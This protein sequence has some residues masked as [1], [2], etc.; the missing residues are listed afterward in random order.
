[1]NAKAAPGCGRRL[2]V[3]CTE[4][5]RLRAR[6]G[7]QRV[8]RSLIRAG[9]SLP[10]ESILPVAFDGARF[11]E[12]GAAD[13][14]DRLASSGTWSV[15]ERLR[16]A[17]LSGSRSAVLRST[18]LHPALQ[19]AARRGVSAAYWRSRRVRR[20]LAQSRPVAYARSDWIVLLDSTWGPD[21]RP[22]LARARA[23]GA[24]VCVVVYDLIQ[25]R[26][27]DLVS[28]GAARIFSQ[29]IERTLPLA[30]R[31]LTISASV[32]ED[33]RALLAERGMGELATRV[34][35]FHLGCD[36]ADSTEGSPSA[37]VAS[38]FEGGSLPATFLAVGTLEPR[39]AQSTLLDAFET[40]WGRG[41]RSR[42]IL[43]GREGWGSHALVARLRCHPERDRRLF[44][45]A[46]ATDADL[47]YCYGRATA[48]LNASL[49]EG[50][51][52]PLVEAAH[53]GA[54]VIAS[55]IAVFR[56]VGGD[57]TIY[58]TPGDAEA[59]ARAVASVR[60][61][62]ETRGTHPGVTWEEAAATLV[63]KLDEAPAVPRY[64][65][66]VRP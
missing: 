42:L 4:T 1:M 53:L 31:I 35:W 9:G 23:A 62:R 17:V 25:L 21:L 55:D 47:R 45:I 29:W 13:L 51:G 3:D 10:D 56:E 28:P 5:A 49:C 6:T 33:L 20:G 30:D 37:G 39:K 18:L 26:R 65:S 63:R 44:W 16:N 57:G 14:S 15:R 54:P 48:V 41:D 38:I 22:E 36:F 11:V 12:A 32:Q 8:V 66:P 43:L 61:R 52:L 34:D 58:V 64:A 27:P 7:I 59:W 2:L 24:R 40:L 19:G 60:V 50:F 46:D